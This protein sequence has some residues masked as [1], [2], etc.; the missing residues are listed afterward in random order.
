LELNRDYFLTH[1]PIDFT[2]AQNSKDFVVEEIPLYEWSGEGEHII[3]KI[4]KKNLSTWEM[5]SILSKKMKINRR[6]IGYAGLKDKNAMTIQYLS[7][8]KKY[9]NLL[10]E[11]LEDETKIAVLEKFTHKNKIKLGHLK[12]NRFFIRL[13]KV[14][15][16]SAT[17]I[18]SVLKKIVDFG[19]PNFFGYQRFGIERDNFRLGKEI[20]DGESKIRDRDK[21]RLFVNAY[22]SML[23]NNWL[24]ERIKFSRLVES[25]GESE[26]PEA[27][28]VMGVELENLEFLKKQKH[29]FKILLGDI[30]LHYPHGRAF[31]VEKESFEETLK[32]FEERDIVPSGVLAGKKAMRSS[33]D[34]KIFED[35]FWEDISIADGERRYSWVFPK[36]IESN[37]REKDFW[38][39][40]NF[41]LPKGSYATTLLEEIGR[42]DLGV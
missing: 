25:F 21:K 14:N 18:E 15:P 30:M 34:A 13:K 10:D 20:I 16:T 27:L 28:K 19:I 4:R 1:A 36:D 38:F 41:Y 37:Y 32:R 11:A 3:L 29:P 17:K 26:L 31:S 8:P 9:E 24:S 6:D 12:G 40:L 33:G 5:I 22:Q 39:E 2:F 7:M 35:K 42:R 23:F